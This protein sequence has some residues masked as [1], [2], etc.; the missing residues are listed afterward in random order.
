MAKFC[1]TATWDDVPHLSKEDKDELWS[2]YPPHERDARA[3][4]IPM[5]GSGAVWP[6][7]EDRIKCEPFLIPAHYV[8]V[9]GVDFGIDHPFA[10]SRIAWDRDADVIYVTNCYK[11]SDETPPVHV[12]TLR[13]WGRWI[14][15]AWPHDGLNREKGS[16]KPLATIY[17]EHGL[18][19]LMEMATHPEGGNSLEASVMDIYERMKTDRFKVFSNLEQWFQEFR[20][21]HRKDGKIVALKDDVIS[22]TRYAVMMKRFATIDPSFYDDEEDSYD[23]RGNE[24]TGY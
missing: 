18:N 8:Q 4:G 13:S 11:Q 14:P 20:L 1:V 17:R 10:G 21:F 22:A 16:G 7:A 19:M 2:A 23:H 9:G 12:A 24:S 15:W 5:L 6:I 3:K